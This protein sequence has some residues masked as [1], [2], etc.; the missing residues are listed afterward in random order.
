MKTLKIKNQKNILRIITLVIGVLTFIMAIVNFVELLSISNPSFLDYLSPII[1]FLNACFLMFWGF[2]AGQISF[3]HENNALL[4]KWETLRGEL[5]QDVDIHSI[6]IN[7]FNL[8]IKTTDGKVRAYNILSLK[9]EDKGSIIS[10]F[11][12]EYSELVKIS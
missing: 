5:F 7:K 1:F 6:D 8:K 9:K 11:K 10:F 2:V 12:E 3:R 4:I